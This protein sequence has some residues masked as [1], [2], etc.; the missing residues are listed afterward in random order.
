MLLQPAEEIRLLLVKLVVALVVHPS[1]QSSDSFSSICE[2]LARALS[3]NFPEVKRECCLLIAKLS[4]KGA[5]AIRMH[6]ER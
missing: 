1:V 3:D 2:G 5:K 4:K 6:A